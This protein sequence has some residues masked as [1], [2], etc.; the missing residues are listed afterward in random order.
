MQVLQRLFFRN[1]PL[2]YSNVAM[3]NLW[4]K[5]ETP[6]TS[7]GF[8]GNI[9]WK[10]Q[11]SPHCRTRTRDGPR[12]AGSQLDSRWTA[13]WTSRFRV[14]IPIFI[15]FACH[16]METNQRWI[17]APFFKPF[18]W[19]NQGP[20]DQSKPLKSQKSQAPSVQPTPNVWSFYLQLLLLLPVV[21]HKAVAEVSKIGNL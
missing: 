16:L 14:R 1:I 15:Q 10:W 9:L 8:K 13:V 18:N 11:L 4:K 2:W 19:T 12:F 7:G 17:G 6:I 3:E 21:P 20:Q 5:H